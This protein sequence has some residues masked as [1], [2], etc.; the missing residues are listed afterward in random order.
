MSQMDDMGSE[1]AQPF[2]V[3][4]SDATPDDGSGAAASARQHEA[5]ASDGCSD[6]PG[7]EASP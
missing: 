4:M 6:V 3:A 5:L 1:G 2:D 7:F